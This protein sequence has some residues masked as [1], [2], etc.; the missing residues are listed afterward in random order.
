MY[1]SELTVLFI[2][3]AYAV[4]GLCGFS[5]CPSPTRSQLENVIGLII[6]DGSNSGTAVIELL[7]FHPVCR[8]FA[9]EQDHFKYM[10][11][12]V[13]YS[14]TGH[15]NCLSG[16]VTEQIET[17]CN[18]GRWENDIL[19]RNFDLRS[20]TTDASFN[21]ITRDDC[22]YCI[23]PELNAA[24]GFSTLDTVTHCVGK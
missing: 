4:V 19:S 20:T 23:S 17:G 9:R 18:L 6:E 12:V 15:A 10:S 5:R 24:I 1:H 3:A 13:Q 2:V 16:T 7:N 21:T 11:L 8:S 22:A 14:C